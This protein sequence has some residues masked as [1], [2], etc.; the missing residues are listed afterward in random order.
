[1]ASFN[2]FN[3]FV[4]DV[5]QKVHN[6]NSD[7]LYIYLTNAAPSASNTV[8]NT[9]ADLSTAGG[10]TAG[11][12]QAFTSTQSYTQSGGLATLTG[13]PTSV[14]WTATTGFGPFRYA[15]LY[16]NTAASK[17]LIGWWDYGSAISIPA[18]GTFTVN[19]ASG[20][21]TLQ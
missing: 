17:N 18:S 11:G 2:K 13:T 4:Q 1:M 16:N 5:G 21:L 14:V 10:Y 7:A 3:C 9:P 20:F 12:L 8:Y 19:F 6:L 15:V